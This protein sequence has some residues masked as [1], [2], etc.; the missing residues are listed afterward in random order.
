MRPRNSTFLPHDPA[1]FLYK[2]KN[3]WW[4]QVFTTFVKT[5]NFVIL[6]SFK[7][8]I[9]EKGDKVSTSSSSGGGGGVADPF[10]H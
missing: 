2:T 9:N 6:C 7:C 10:S 1:K 8:R 5:N 4:K 3:I